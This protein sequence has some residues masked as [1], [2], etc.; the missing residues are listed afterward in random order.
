MCNPLT[1]TLKGRKTMLC[2][3]S[4]DTPLSLSLSLSLFSS[5]SSSSSS[6]SFFFF[7]FFFF[8][9]FFSLLFPSPPSSPL[10]LLPSP[11]S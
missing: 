9:V 6:S 11:F 1:W 3:F 2:K 7:F 4:P 5:S 8:S 10:P